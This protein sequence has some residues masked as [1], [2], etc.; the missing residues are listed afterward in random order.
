MIRDDPHGLAQRRHVLFTMLTTLGYRYPPSREPAV[1]AGS[2]QYLGGWL[3]IGR[4]VAG[5]A[6]QQYALQLMRFGQDG[7]SATFYPA[8]IAHSL[9]PMVGSGWGREPWTAVQRTA[10]EALR[11]REGE[12]A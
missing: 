6:H 11:R 5:M 10:W 4:V 3:G 12:A 2:G 7:W 9:T 1:I 8:G